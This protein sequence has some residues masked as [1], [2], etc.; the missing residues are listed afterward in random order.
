MSDILRIRAPHVLDLVCQYFHPSN[1]ALSCSISIQTADTLYLL[2][3][4]HMT[5][6]FSTLQRRIFHSTTL[7]GH[8]WELIDAPTSLLY[9][10]IYMLTWKTEELS[11]SIF[12]FSDVKPEKI[13]IELDLPILF[14]F[15][16][17]GVDFIT[18]LSHENSKQ[19]FRHYIIAATDTSTMAAL[20][21]GAITIRDAFSGPL[22]WHAI[23][24][25]NGQTKHS[26]LIKGALKAVPKNYLP[27]KR[28]RVPSVAPT[29]NDDRERS[30]SITLIEYGEI[31]RKRPGDGE[32]PMNQYS[33][34]ILI[35][36][37]PNENELDSENYSLL[38]LAA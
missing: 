21:S 15:N 2:I 31:A 38:A 17:N 37:T 13:F 7:G 20:E 36:A 10:R 12:D 30:I 14:S 35:A 19:D 24:N 23:T 5:G 27:S 9:Q 26:A 34:D 16:S 29:H 33:Y 8:M 3:F 32:L 1:P 28:A 6:S 11:Q 4:T 25:N 22:L 18:Y